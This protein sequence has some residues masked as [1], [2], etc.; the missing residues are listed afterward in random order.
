MR[1][2]ALVLALGL[3]QSA[4]SLEA[5]LEA[6]FSY[7]VAYE[8][9]L[10]EFVAD[11]EMQQ[12]RLNAASTLDAPPGATWR[13]WQAEI[14][15]TRLP[16]GGSWLGYRNVLVVDGKPVGNDE[17]LQNLLT[18]GAD[19]K[20]RAVDLAFA[21]ARFNLGTS[22]T[23]NMPTLPLE[24]VHP[25]HRKRLTYKLHGIERVNGRQLRRVSFEEHLRPTLIRDPDGGDLWSRGSIWIEESTSRI[26]EAEVRSSSTLD[27][28]APDSSLRVTFATQAGM[29]ILVPVRMREIFPFRSGRGSGDAR[30]SN[31]RRFATAA[32][33][34]PQP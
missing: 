12:S 33:I 28:H 34:V 17:R 6:V 13:K 23:T 15:F 29:D 7:V 5:T 1:A 30:Y 4:P 25:R 9:R 31:F 24:F 20:K 21:S 2:G 8:A 19:E 14:A 11:E 3:L 22:R 27:P 18:R 10:V 26:F 16:G 32:R